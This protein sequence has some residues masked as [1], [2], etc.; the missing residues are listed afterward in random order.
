MLAAA[1]AVLADQA[2]MEPNPADVEDL[3]RAIHAAKRCS[4]DP[5]EGDREAARTALLWMRDR[6]TRD[7]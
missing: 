4:G 5:T 3:A 1:I 2:D 7:A 6:E